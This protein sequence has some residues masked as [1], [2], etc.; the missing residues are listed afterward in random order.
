M[1]LLCEIFSQP[2]GAHCEIKGW[3][4]KWPSAAKWSCSPIATLCENFRSCENSLGT[5]VPFRSPPT[6]FRSCEMACENPYEIPPWL[7]NSLRKCPLVAKMTFGCKITSGLWNGCKIASKLRNDL[8]ATKL[9][10]EM[11][12]V[13]EN[14]LRSQGKLRKCQ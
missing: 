3:L 10:Y 13:R 7:R 9:T 4:R 12:E 6:P 14:T 11:G 1:A 2:Q 8:Q 5:Q